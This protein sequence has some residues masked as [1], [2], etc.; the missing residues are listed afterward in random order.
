[1]TTAILQTKLYIPPVRPDLVPRPRLLERLNAGLDRRMTLLSASAGFGKTTLLSEWIW[2][3]G[4]RPRVAW[5][6]VD[7]GDNDPSRF[8][9]YLGAALG[10]VQRS[11]EASAPDAEPSPQS[12]SMEELLTALINQISATPDRA[13]VLVLDDYHLIRTQAVHDAVRFLL[14]YLP[15]NLH[16]VM[17]TRFDPPLP[18][19][20]LR[21]RGQLTEVRQADLRFDADE[22]AAFLSQSIGPALSAHDIQTLISRTEGWAAG[23]QMAALAMESSSTQGRGDVGAFVRA[24][25]GSNRYIMDYLVEQ[26]L[27]RQPAHVQAFLLQTAILERLSGPL[28]DAVLDGGDA[29]ARQGGDCQAT[30]EYL[31]RTNLFVEPLDDHRA[32]YRY[33]RLFAD[34]LRSR[35]KQSYG[36]LVPTLHRRASAWYRIQAESAGDHELLG[37]AIDHALAAEDYEQAACMVEQ[38]AEAT[39][40]RSEIATFVAWVEAL[41]DALVS[42]RPALYL[43]HSWALLLGGRSP[44]SIERRVQKLA[45]KGAAA[46]GAATLLRAFTLMFK[47]QVPRATAL[48]RQALEQLPEDDV[49]SRT[50]AALN[51]GISFL[52]AGDSQAAGQVLEETARLG[53][54]SGQVMIAVI[55]ISHL[56]EQAMGE[57]Q[58]RK[59]RAR[60]ERALELATDSRGRLLPIG[61]M[62][63]C[64]LGTLAWE[65][66]ELDE[67]RRCLAE[68]IELSKQWGQL[69]ALDGYAWLARVKQAQGDGEGARRAMQKA[70]QITGTMSIPE[71]VELLLATF[72]MRLWL[73]QGDL[74]A[75]R[76]W[77]EGRRPGQKGEG[78]APE[79][80]DVVFIDSLRRHKHLAL[81]RLSL[82]QERPGEALSLLEPWLP[83]MERRGR[84]GR[85]IEIELL[86]G[87]AFQAQGDTPQAM[88]AMKHALS[89]AEPEGYVRIF[90][91]EGRPMAKLLYEAAARGIAPGYAGR[92]L[93]AFPEEADAAAPGR[94]AAGMVEPLSERELE[95]L[96]LIAEGLS[97]REIAGQLVVSLSTVKGHTS[98]IYGKLA[99]HSR[100]QAI[101]KAR[102]MGILPDV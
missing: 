31:E 50:L 34:L 73:A 92:L 55:A 47:G 26:V 71:L 15:A 88:R 33:H 8:L 16:M 9:A 89:L 90:V 32:W 51:M 29:M 98:N 85:V 84:I 81:A 68:G 87:L 53:S 36:D 60:Y 46:S 12:P 1:M 76:R 4:L 25:G 27:D 44:D 57:G 80:R 23:L 37:A 66:N 61:S 38:S 77:A 10:K 11:V 101:G 94:M 97:N 13:Y 59:A 102:M 14:D 30:L 95:V 54:E 40:M 35:L 52:I 100:T 39:V 2:R 72:Q 7:D 17:A 69:G 45:G 24:F 62:A 93:A 5:L 19:A 42:A 70:R 6:S 83:E 64:G 18:I 56:A 99:V 78:A 91:E 49:F 63:L 58:L 82:A 43:L 75:A 96:A 20:L 41:P 74:E 21:G 48:S 65:W 3:C 79:A 28:C 67:A 22:A 86:R